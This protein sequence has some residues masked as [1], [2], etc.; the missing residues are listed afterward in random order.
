[1]VSIVIAV[2]NGGEYIKKTVESCLN[3]E[4]KDIEIVI[5]DDCSTEDVRKYIPESEKITYYRNEK[6]L[7]ACG[8][9]NKGIEM[10]KG[11]FILVLG[12]DD[13]LLKNHI[14]EML[15]CFRK[16]TSFVYCDYKV[17]NEKDDIVSGLHYGNESKIISIFGLSTGNKLHSCGLISRKSS[18]VQVGGYS[19]N[20]KYPNYGE[21]DLW[22][23]LLTVGEAAFCDTTYGLY[24]RHSGNMTSEQ[25][26][27][28]NAKILFEYGCWCRKLAR[29]KGKFSV[30][31]KLVYTKSYIG[32][33]VYYN[34]KRF[35]TKLGIYSIYK[36]IKRKGI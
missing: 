15:K 18:L 2:Y 28:R 12:Q 5:I 9:F 36:W 33:V 24:R 31:Q 20:T 3:Q 7:G 13:L 14:S 23:K 34:V 21:W 11:E 22:I 1:M 35:T 16:N 4:F 17:I 30:M 8:A 27:N 19:Y 25:N 29:D 10:S 6:N 32:Y 26:T